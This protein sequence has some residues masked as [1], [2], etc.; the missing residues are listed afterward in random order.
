MSTVVAASGGRHDT[1]IG[2]RGDRRVKPTSWWS[3]FKPGGR[4]AYMRRVDEQR[5]PYYVD[6]F[7]WTSGF[8]A[9][10]LVTLSMVDA[11]A[12]LLLLELGGEEIN[13]AMRFLI[14]YGTGAFLIGKLV[15]TGFAVP[16]LLIAQNLYLF[17]TKFNVSYALP[18]LV[19][20]YVI[21]NIYQLVLFSQV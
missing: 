15:L 21:L 11:G 18:T 17:G 8:L 19:V 9:L 14:E 16:V 20:M 2:S 5:Q 10:L 13:P 12:T 3:A 4:R 6:R 7:S 1:Q